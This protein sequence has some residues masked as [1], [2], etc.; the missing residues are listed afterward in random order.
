MV[1]F[2]GYEMPSSTKASSPSISG[3]ATNAGLFDVSHMGQLTIGDSVD[4]RLETLMPGDS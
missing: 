1:P 2:A 3:P 4:R